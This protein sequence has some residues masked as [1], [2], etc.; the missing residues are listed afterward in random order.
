MPY[1]NAN[2]RD[3]DFDPEEDFGPAAEIVTFPTSVQRKIDQAASLLRGGDAREGLSLM[4]QA[5]VD[6]ARADPLVFAGLMAAQMGVTGIAVSRQVRTVKTIQT[7]RRAFGVRYG[8]D[9]Q[10]TTDDYFEQ[11]SVSFGG[12]LGGQR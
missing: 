6:L 4:H 3:Y 11:R 7:E 9:L 10:T 8:Q 2:V 1:E 12:P 5:G